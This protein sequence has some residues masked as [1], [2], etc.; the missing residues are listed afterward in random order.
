M[1]SGVLLVGLNMPNMAR[2]GRAAADAART[3][4]LP[5]SVDQAAVGHT[6]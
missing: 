2:A 4:R 5:T 1:G 3:E 6:A